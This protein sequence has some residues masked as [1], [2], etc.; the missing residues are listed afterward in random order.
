ML[1]PGGG[2]EYP[3]AEA[4]SEWYGSNLHIFANLMR[5]IKSPEDRVLVIYGQGHAK[6]LRSFVEDSPD[7]QFVDPLTVLK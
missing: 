4:V 2:N 1:Q 5:L 3:G 6:L 7:L